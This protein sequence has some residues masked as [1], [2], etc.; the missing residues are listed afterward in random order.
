MASLVPMVRTKSCARTPMYREARSTGKRASII[1][2]ICQVDGPRI[3]KSEIFPGLVAWIYH[4]TSGL[5]PDG[6]CGPRSF[7]LADDYEGRPTQWP[8]HGAVEKASLGEG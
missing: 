2:E 4:R 7:V 8:T 1:Q 3:Q 6:S 5:T